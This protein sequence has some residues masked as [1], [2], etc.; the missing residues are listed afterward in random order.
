MSRKFISLIVAAAITVT[1]VSLAAPAKAGNDDLAK[2]LFGATA[3]VIIGKAL[4]DRGHVTVVAPQPKPKPK[5]VYPHRKV[6]DPRALPSNCLRGVQT[7]NGK[8]SL[9]NKSCLKTHYRYTHSLPQTCAV[10][11]HSNGAMRA[12]YNMQC[13]KQRGYFAVDH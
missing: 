2:F 13:L 9:M 6:R 11:V 12:G 7:W 1:G 8:V 5:K 10:R 4:D 3:L